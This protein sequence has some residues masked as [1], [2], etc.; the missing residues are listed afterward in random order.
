MNTD[1]E[2]LKVLA[3]QTIY[4]IKEDQTSRSTGIYPKGTRW[5]N[6]QIS[7]S[8]IKSYQQNEKQTI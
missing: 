7:T 2:I 4:Y 1:A 5:F 8:T 3:N 6:K